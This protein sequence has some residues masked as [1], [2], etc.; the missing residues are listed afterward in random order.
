MSEIDARHIPKQVGI[1]FVIFVHQVYYF[2]KAQ[3][4]PCHQVYVVTMYTADV[5]LVY[6]EYMKT[7]DG[8]YSKKTLQTRSVIHTSNQKSNNKWTFLNWVTN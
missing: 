6:T 7:A 4:I 1:T 3:N 5:C 8:K 2:S